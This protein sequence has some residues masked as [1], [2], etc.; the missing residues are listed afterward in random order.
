MRAATCLLAVGHPAAAAAD[1]GLLP[2]ADRPRA[3]PREVTATDLLRLRD[4]GQ[5]DSSGFGLTGPFDVS[6][7][8]KQVAF[9]VMRDDPQANRRCRGVVTLTLGSGR[10]R[11]LDEGG[12]DILA[13][14]RLR[15]AQIYQGSPKIV[16]PLWS[17]DQKGIAYLRRDA[18]VVQAW[19]VPVSGGSARAVSRGDSNVEALQWSVDGKGLILARRH[20]EIRLTQ[21]LDR[22]GESGYLY[23]ARVW[24]SFGPRPRLP[25]GS[26]ITATYLD[27]ATGEERAAS[28]QEAGRLG[29][30][31]GDFTLVKAEAT[32]GARSAGSRSSEM[33]A[34]GG[35]RIVARLTDGS[36]YVCSA[37]ACAGRVLNLW[38]DG[39]DLL[40][41]RRE[42]WANRFV[43]LYRWHPGRA[44]PRRLLR[45]DDALQGCASAPGELVCTAESLVRPRRI[46]AIDKRS[47]AVRTAFDLNPE[48]RTIALGTA[49]RL[50]WRNARGQE[51]RGDLALPAGLKAGARVPLVIVQYT[52]DG[53][54]RGGTGDEYPIWL[55]A[56][57]GIAILRIEKTRYAG[58]DPAAGAA[59]GHQGPWA[60]RWDLLSTVEAGIDTVIAMGVADPDRIGI[61]GLSDGA[62]TVAFALINGRHY[63]AAAMSSCCTE[64]ES[65]MIY[66][67]AKLA[68]SLHADGFPLLTEHD[69]GFWKPMS[70]AQSAEHV[71]TPLLMQ[72][73]DNEFDLALPAFTA[74]HEL[75]RPVEM[76]V[77][78]DEYHVKI[79][80]RHRLAVYQRNV[81]WFDFWLLGRR[82]PD[83]TKAGQ[84]AR[85][86]L[87]RQTRPRASGFTAAPAPTPRHRQIP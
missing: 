65:M 26:P 9:V 37:E 69:T 83:P 61:T 73:A 74:L 1:C 64:P 7:D 22:E 10:A 44:A 24:P 13:V 6:P 19:L 11:L 51:A 81:D 79:Q 33:G 39:G 67:G 70:I 35:Q 52:S 40:I 58:P 62:T 15:G 36:D 29:G 41:L 8:G 80:P 63:A 20:D 28:P 49:H 38:W 46:V 78:P 82:D 2:T 68:E 71:T 50:T 18:G 60:D 85:W 45:T 57:D 42:G 23:D 86:D 77:F 48:F 17:P 75:S 59:P 47:G 4:V 87:M 72:L 53:F 5:P 21:A 30:A 25:T 31:I 43:A 32:D 84:Y 12:E 3:M 54:L 14:N 34:A 27:L 16:V 56:R 76:Y 55:L 66:G